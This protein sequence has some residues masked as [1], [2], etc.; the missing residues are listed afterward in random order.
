[1]VNT[2]SVT[3]SLSE[4]YQADN[5]MAV[6]HTT[7]HNTTVEAESAVKAIQLIVGMYKP[8]KIKITKKG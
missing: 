8:S 2:Y 3:Y 1:M 4:T 6:T 5:S 7:E